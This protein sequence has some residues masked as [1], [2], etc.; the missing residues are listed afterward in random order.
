MPK[1]SRFYHIAAGAVLACALAYLA[2]LAATSKLGPDSLVYLGVV[3]FAPIMPLYLILTSIGVHAE[4]NLAG[5]LGML[6]VWGVIGGLVGLL[7]YERNIYRASAQGGD[8]SAS[9]GLRR[10]RRVWWIIGICGFVYMGVGEAI[11]FHQAAQ[12]YTGKTSPI[13]IS[14]LSGETH[15]KFPPG[16]LLVA[17]EMQKDWRATV[18]RAKIEMPR[19]ALDEF[20]RANAFSRQTSLRASPRGLERDPRL[21]WWDPLSDEKNRTFENQYSSLGPTIIV[22]AHL[23]KSQRCVVYIYYFQD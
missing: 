7:R 8:E 3:L 1:K 18:I 17:S 10:Y 13:T 23:D 6:L 19:L 11:V 2:W 14:E 9:V 5:L 15:L 16:T 20:A 22:L 4:S 21:P 12:A